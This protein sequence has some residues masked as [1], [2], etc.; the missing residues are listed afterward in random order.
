MYG[1]HVHQLQKFLVLI[2]V[3]MHI[4]LDFSPLEKSMLNFLYFSAHFFIF[5]QICI[6]K[7]VNLFTL[8][9][10][11]K[12]CSYAFA[13]W[14]K[15]CHRTNE[16]LCRITHAANISG[17]NQ[18][19]MASAGRAWRNDI[20]RQLEFRKAAETDPYSDLVNSRKFEQMIINF[21]IVAAEGVSFKGCFV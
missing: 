11:D 16:N 9:P 2:C 17:N 6:G 14:E 20:L 13:V 19:K 12:P 21:W 15:P 4:K 18:N 5:Q 1:S 7:L 8:V 3:L 10:L